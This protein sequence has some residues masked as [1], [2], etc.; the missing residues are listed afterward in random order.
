MGSEPSIAEHIRQIKGNAD[1]LD[2]KK[3]AATKTITFCQLGHHFWYNIHW[4]NLP[5]R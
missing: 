1:A 4:E 5:L 2:V 3:D